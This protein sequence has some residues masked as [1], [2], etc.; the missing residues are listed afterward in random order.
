LL[1]SIKDEKNTPNNTEKTVKEETVGE[2]ET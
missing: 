2:S 1:V